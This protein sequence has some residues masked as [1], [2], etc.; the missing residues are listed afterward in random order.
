MPAAVAAKLTSRVTAR[1]LRNFLLT[2]PT[3]RPR[4]PAPQLPNAVR[5]VPPG[6]QLTPI[7]PPPR[8]PQPAMREPPV[9]R[10]PAA[11]PAAPATAST[12]KAPGISQWPLAGAEEPESRRDPYPA[13]PTGPPGGSGSRWGA[14]REAKGDLSVTSE[15]T[16]LLANG[17]VMQ[18]SNG[19]N[20]VSGNGAANG[21]RK[22]RREEMVM[23]ALPLPTSVPPSKQLPE[24]AS[25]PG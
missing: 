11:P 19:I 25:R 4:G 8:P 12:E 7:P 1:S 18:S 22:K 17:V 2:I 5:T 10:S 9:S 15:E 16:I 23:V 24:R 21:K 13:Q 20:G 3:P 6:P 14:R